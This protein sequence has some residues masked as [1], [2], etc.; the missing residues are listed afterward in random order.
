M[1]N[2]LNKLDID[3]I[4]EYLNDEIMSK[5]YPVICP[6]TK[7]DATSYVEQEIKGWAAGCRYPFSIIINN[8]F[9]GV[10]ALYD[11]NRTDRTSKIYY[12]VAVEFWGLGIATKAVKQ[13]LKYARI[14]LELTQLTTG[15]LERNIGSKRVLEKNG[16]YVEKILVNEGKYHGKFLGEKFLEMKLNLKNSSSMKPITKPKAH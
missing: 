2:S 12:W 13:L 7:D 4:Q 10:C 6:F 15:V 3:Y 9:V 8:K 14:E 11:V 16:F 5:T 1:L